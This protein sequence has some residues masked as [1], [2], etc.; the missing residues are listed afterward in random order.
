L[1]FWHPGVTA[2]AL[3]FGRKFWESECYGPQKQPSTH[4]HWEQGISLDPS[5]ASS[6]LL[7]KPV[8]IYSSKQTGVSHHLQTIVCSVIR[9]KVSENKMVF[10]KQENRLITYNHMC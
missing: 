7:L 8:K 5:P 9:T 10:K 3:R 2:K 6:K 1:E 4:D